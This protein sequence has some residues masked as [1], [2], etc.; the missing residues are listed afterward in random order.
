MRLYHL[1]SILNRKSI[2]ENGLFINSGSRSK[3]FGQKEK[4]IYLFDKL[5]KL[6]RL[7]NNPFWNTHPDFNDGFD[8]YEI[9]DKVAIYKDDKFTLG[10]YTKSNL[11]NIKLVCTLNRS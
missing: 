9:Y 7:K 6:N 5:W 4:R 11:K 1:T 2:L 8:I 3:A 10:Y